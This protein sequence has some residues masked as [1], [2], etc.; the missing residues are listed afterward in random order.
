MYCPYWNVLCKDEPLYWHFMTCIMIKIMCIS[1][2][3]T[4]RSKY[5][6]LWLL[7]R[8]YS[9]E[10]IE[11]G[12]MSWCVNTVRWWY[13]GFHRKRGGSILQ[14]VQ[15]LGDSTPSPGIRIRR[16]SASGAGAVEWLCWESGQWHRGHWRVVWRQWSSG[17]AEHVVEQLQ[18]T[19]SPGAGPSAECGAAQRPGTGS[20]VHA[21]PASP[22][23]AVSCQTTVTISTTWVTL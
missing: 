6:L 14:V 1:K 5:L 20:S 2:S 12:V 3:V 15:W 9:V 16:N 4:I 17:A 21:A 19:F 18:L 8:L 7:C 13:K 23:P 10:S 11:Q 22:G